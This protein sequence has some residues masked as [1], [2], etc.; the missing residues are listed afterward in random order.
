MLR[1]YTLREVEVQE[2]SGVSRKDGGRVSCHVERAL[3]RRRRNVVED[4]WEREAEKRGSDC[5][6]GR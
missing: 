2:V 5:A 4:E 6:A 3:V 1:R